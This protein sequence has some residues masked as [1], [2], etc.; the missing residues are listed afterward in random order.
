MFGVTNR[1]SIDWFVVTTDDQSVYLSVVATAL[2]T[3]RDRIRWDSVIQVC[4][5]AKPGISYCLYV[6]TSLR[7]ESWVIPV[8]AT[9]GTQSL[10]ALVRRGL[11][12]AGLAAKATS[13]PTGLFCWPPAEP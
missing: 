3:W 9:G 13:S 12:D 1:G 4:V 2:E 10:D 7:P 8:E 6:F 11:F 5:E